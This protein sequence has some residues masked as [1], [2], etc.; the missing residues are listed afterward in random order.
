MKNF[1][2][3]DKISGSKST[4][5]PQLPS[6]HPEHQLPRLLDVALTLVLSPKYAVRVFTISINFSFSHL[7]PGDDARWKPEPICQPIH[8]WAHISMLLLV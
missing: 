4:Q 2:C 6:E 8:L 1:R 5:H 3:L 7:L